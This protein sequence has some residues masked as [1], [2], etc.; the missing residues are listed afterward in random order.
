MGSACLGITPTISGHFITGPWAHPLHEGK[1]RPE[2]L[3]EL[4]QEPPALREK[5]TSSLAPRCVPARRNVTRISKPMPFLKITP[6]Y[7]PNQ[8]WIWGLRFRVH[9]LS[10]YFLQAHTHTHT[11]RQTDRGTSEEISDAPMHPEDSRPEVPA[12]LALRPSGAP[13][14]PRW[15]AAP[16]A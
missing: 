11:H 1:L 9:S 10:S 8:H 6:L 12:W 15:P 13:S 7:G 3:Q 2:R 14:R 5:D 16:F 4:A